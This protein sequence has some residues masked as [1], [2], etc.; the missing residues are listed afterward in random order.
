MDIFVG[1]SYTSTPSGVLTTHIRE[2]S[3]L[4]VA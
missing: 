4:N 2:K 3:V 1:N